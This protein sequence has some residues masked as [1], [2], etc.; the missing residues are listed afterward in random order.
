MQFLSII[1]SLLYPSA[2]KNQVSLLAVR[3]ASPTDAVFLQLSP[4]GNISRPVLKV[5]GQLACECGLR[6]MFQHQITTCAN[7]HMYDRQ[8]PSHRE[9]VMRSGLT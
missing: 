9:R 8:C 4:R 6:K 7:E 2:V 5:V 3:P 1:P